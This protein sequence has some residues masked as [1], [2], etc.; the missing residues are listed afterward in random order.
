MLGGSNRLF[1]RSLNE[2]DRV[3]V[4]D[5]QAGRVV[6]REVD[7]F[8][9]P[10]TLKYGRVRRASGP[11]RSRRSCATRRG[12]TAR[13]RTC[14]RSGSSRRRWCRSTSPPRRPAVVAALDV[15]GPHLGAVR[16][17][18]EVVG[19]PA[20]LLERRVGERTAAAAGSSARRTASGRRSRAGSRRCRRSD[21][22]PARR[23]R[24]AL[25][26]GSSSVETRLPASSNT[27]SCVQV[28]PPSVD[29]SMKP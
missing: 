5:Q 20:A 10:S 29:T 2:C 12:S 25:P 6:R 4:P 18:R 3:P 1:A 27:S 24:P 7:T 26:F 13:T 28:A 9:S 17:D 11:C 19:E 23:S 21:R 14:R 15:V 16:G 22:S 8:H